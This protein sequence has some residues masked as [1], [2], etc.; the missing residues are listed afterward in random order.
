MGFNSG[1][2]GLISCDLSHFRFEVLQSSEHGVSIFVI[3][4]GVCIII[5]D[6]L[7]SFV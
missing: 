2:K 7:F 3:Q 1:F 4:L 6:N 5:L